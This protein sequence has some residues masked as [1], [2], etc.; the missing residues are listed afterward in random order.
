MLR[1]SPVVQVGNSRERI[2]RLVDRFGRRFS[3]ELDIKLDH[4]DK[5]EVFKWFVASILFGSR[6]SEKI[7]IKTYRKFMENGLDTPDR[8]VEAGWDRLVEVLDSGGYARYDF[9]TATK[10]IEVMKNL[11]G[12][13]RGDLRRLHAEASS[14]AD[15]EMKIKQLGKGIGD[16]TVSIFLRELRGIWR[17]AD[18]PLQELAITAAQSLGLTKREG[19]D[20]AEKLAILKELRRLWSRNR[21]KGKSFIDFETALVR[22]GKD[23]LRKKMLGSR[24]STGR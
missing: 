21:I 18:P 24:R 6:I 7:A 2:A 23:V 8:I 15:L 22:Y 14:P 11:R 5:D 13:Y 1:G 10:M 12:R 16:V 20:E 19:R 4:S 3:E 17:Y 9:K